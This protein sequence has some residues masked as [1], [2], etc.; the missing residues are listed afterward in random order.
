MRNLRVALALAAVLLATMSQAF[1]IDANRWRELSEEMRRGYVTAVVD[2]WFNFNALIEGRRSH[3]E[4]TFAEHVECLNKRKFTYDQ[5]F[6]E[7]VD[8]VERRKDRR[9]YNMA[10][11]TWN[12]VSEMCK[13]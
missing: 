11:V 8:Y 13:R 6:N 12:A 4:R 10:A 2:T 5:I 9:E 1:A 7:T 3:A